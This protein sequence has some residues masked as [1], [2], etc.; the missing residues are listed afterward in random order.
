MKKNTIEDLFTHLKNDFDFEEPKANHERRFLGKLNNNGELQLVNAPKQRRRLWK[1]LIGVAAS[2]VLLLTVFISSK[3][4]D[5]I[6]DLASVSP[7]MAETQDFFTLT[8]NEELTK[9]N[10]ESSPEVQ[11]LIN[12]A[13]AQIKKLEEDYSLLKE[14]LIESGDDNR[15]IYAMISNFQNRIDILQNTLDQIKQVK[16]LKNSSN[17]EASE[18]II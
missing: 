8:I 5:A 4:E 17:Y 9:L 12:D 1:P 6:G 10:Q 2:I 11:G 7:Q 18:T 3:P 14:D 16:Q 15:V 13:L